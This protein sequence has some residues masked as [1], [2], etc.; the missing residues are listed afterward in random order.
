MSHSASLKKMKK[1]SHCK[2]MKNVWMFGNTTI[3]QKDLTTLESW[4]KD[5]EMSFHPEKWIIIHI[6]KIKRLVKV[7]YLL[8]G[9]TLESVPGGK[10]LGMC[11]SQDLS[12]C[13]HINQAT[14][15]TYRSVGFLRCNLSSWPQDVKAL[16]L[17]NTR[18]SLNMPWQYGTLTINSKSNKLSEY[19]ARQPESSI[20][21]AWMRYQHVK[22]AG[23]KGCTNILIYRYAP[24]F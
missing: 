17:H 20:K 14:A 23:S 9:H 21:G 11:I 6:T 19:N 10:Y 12:W 18:T 5:C 4:E 8:H 13:D 24:V 15:K 1:F 2:A 16:G 7:D 3:L 22:P